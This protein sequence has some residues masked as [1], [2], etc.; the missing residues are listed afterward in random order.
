MT[1]YFEN[2]YYSLFYSTT[3][4]SRVTPI[5]KTI[6]EFCLRKHVNINILDGNHKLKIVSERL[7]LY[8][9]FFFQTIFERRNFNLLL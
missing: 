3:T 2:Y 9:C 5:I 6:C 7:S 4:Q 8:S 1:Q